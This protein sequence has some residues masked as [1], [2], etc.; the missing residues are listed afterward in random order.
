M[1]TIE[2][3]AHAFE[4]FPGIGPRQ[5]K[6]FVYHLLSSGSSDRK[7]LAK[8]IEKIGESVHQCAECKRFANIK[9]SVCNYC[10]DRSRDDG[11][12]M[13][14]EKDQDLAAVERAGT[15]KGRYFVLGGVLTLSGKGA[16][17]EKELLNSIEK[18]VPLG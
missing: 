5:A 3:L 13:V 14:L 18:R 2:E 9:G 10:S 8:L 6:R 15:Y 17:R 12:L 11:V 7:E 1:E 4:R 16:I